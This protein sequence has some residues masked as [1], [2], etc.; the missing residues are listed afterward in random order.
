MKDGTVDAKLPPGAPLETLLTRAEAAGTIT[1]AEAALVRAARDLTAQVI[2]VDDF[3]QDLGASE[4]KLDP[5]APQ[6]SAAPT[7]VHKAAA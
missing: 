6:V 3:P 4:M 5:G 7:I 2:R 1:A